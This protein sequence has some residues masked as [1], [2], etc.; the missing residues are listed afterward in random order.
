MKITK[1]Q[2]KEIIEEELESI[3]SEQE[4]QKYRLIIPQAFCFQAQCMATMR[5]IELE[6]GV[7]V[8]ASKGPG[9]TKEEAMQVAKANLAKKLQAK[10]LDMNKIQVLK[11]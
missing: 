10:G 7:I 11:K 3:L 2:L 8:T 5:V 1:S 9:K 6:T 4:E